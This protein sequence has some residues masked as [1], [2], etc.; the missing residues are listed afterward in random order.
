[1]SNA[2]KVEVVWVLVVGGRNV[3][4]TQRLVRVANRWGREEEKNRVYHLNEGENVY[5]AG[6][7]VCGKNVRD[8][9]RCFHSELTIKG[10]TG[11]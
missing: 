6:M 10:F 8:H 4:N 5:D 9:S 1:M 7:L 2:G 3:P 11:A